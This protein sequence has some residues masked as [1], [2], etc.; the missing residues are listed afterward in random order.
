MHLH[1][2]SRSRHE[3]E[4]GATGTAWGRRTLP[5]LRCTIIAHHLDTVTRDALN[6]TR[7]PSMSTVQRTRSAF[8]HI[9]VGKHSPRAQHERAGGDHRH[10]PPRRLARAPAPRVGRPLSLTRK[11]VVV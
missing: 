2:R 11:L 3:R 1:V 9:V 5:I 6:K 4:T 7:T 8:P 10:L